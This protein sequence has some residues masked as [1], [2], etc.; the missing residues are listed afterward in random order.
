MGHCDR[1]AVSYSPKL[2]T[3][4][5]DTG[6]ARL[7]STPITQR[8][9]GKQ[10]PGLK[11]RMRKEGIAESREEC[12]GQEGQSHILGITWRS[13]LVRNGLFVG[14]EH[15]KRSVLV[16]AICKALRKCFV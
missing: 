9:M 2:S 10:Q 1:P 14:G 12:G 4:S 15:S 11:V 5:S 8:F 16:P 6:P 3:L 13:H 7:I